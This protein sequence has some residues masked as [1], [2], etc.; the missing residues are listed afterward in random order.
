MK[1]MS[2]DSGDGANKGLA[3]Y[4]VQPSAGAKTTIYGLG[5]CTMDITAVDCGLWVAQAVAELPNYCQ[6]A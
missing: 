5:W 4:M 6:T 3:T 1:L 2:N